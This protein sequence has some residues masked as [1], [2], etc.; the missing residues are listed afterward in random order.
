MKVS[1][2]LLGVG[3]G[4][5]LGLLLK[6]ASEKK[7]LTPERALKAVKQAVAQEHMITGSWIHMIP[8]K[9]NYENDTYEVYRGGIS[10][11][12]AEGTKQYEFLV[13]RATGHVLDLMAS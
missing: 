9:I 6:P 12:T 3:I 10:A 5:S 13:D 8:E 1:R 2:L 11:K 7:L 4:I